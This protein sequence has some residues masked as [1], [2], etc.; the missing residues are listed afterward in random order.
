MEALSL[1]KTVRFPYNAPMI[2][3]LPSIAQ[4][5]R[6]AADLECARLYNAGTKVTTLARL[7]GV[8]IGQVYT[9]LHRAEALGLAVL[10]RQASKRKSESNQGEENHVRQPE[11]ASETSI[12]Q[13]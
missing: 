13:D 1:D 5:N 4:R 11:T 6:R 2:A 7:Y 12:L 9:M 10:W 3:R 8:R